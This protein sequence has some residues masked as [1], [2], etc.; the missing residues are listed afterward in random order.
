MTNFF[1]W[2]VSLLLA[3]GLIII[4][5]LDN[6]PSILI[7]GIIFIFLGIVFIMLLNWKKNLQ[8]SITFFLLFF[9]IYL[10]YSSIIHFGLI[11][12]HDVKNLRLDEIF[13]YTSSNDVYLKLK[14]GYTYAEISHIQ[15]YLDTSG[16]IYFSGL[17][18]TLANLYGENSVL[19][20]KMAIIF[21]ASLIPMVT[22]S[23]SRLY[24]SQRISIY[25]GIIYG[26]FS[27]VMFLSSLLLRDLHIALMFIITIYII[28]QKISLSN[29]IILLFVIIFS[30]HLR[31]ETGIFM[32][33]F[34]SIYFFVFIHITIKDKYIKYMLYLF[35]ASVTLLV[36]LNTSL[37]EMFDKMFENS[38]QRSTELATTSSMGAMIAKLPFGL[39]VLALFG[40]G[41]IQ[42]FPPSFIFQGRGKGWFEMSYLIA[43]ISWSI[44]WGFLIYGSVKQKILTKLD[45][46]LTLM[47]VLAVVYLALTSMIE[48]NPRRQMAVYPILYM[49][50]VLSYLNMTITQ[51]T[52]IWVGTIIFY[53]ILVLTINYIKI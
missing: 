48:F 6:N 42:P 3:I 21:I 24:L 53:L 46:K 11:N 15:N 41:Q 31:E 20:Q 5:Y 4:S 38:S 32:L 19:T 25:V 10:F 33:G 52:K 7:L 29:I 16:A 35:L 1:L 14:D 12:F 44:G 9:L 45:M 17:I 22:Y 47:L 26:L 43:G 18:A 51:R 37:V 23:I 30:Y 49:V 8:D 40:F 27:F 50:M 13:F 28:L 2:L 34:L 36:V 39:N